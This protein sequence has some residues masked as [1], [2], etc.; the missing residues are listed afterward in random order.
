MWM[1]VVWL[2]LLV[3]TLAVRRGSIPGTKVNLMKFLLG[4]VQHLDRCDMVIDRV[5]S[6]FAK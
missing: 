3:E 4:F 2:G 1:R 5:S 6:R